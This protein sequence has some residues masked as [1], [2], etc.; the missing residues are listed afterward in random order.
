M[1]IDLGQVSH[2]GIAGACDAKGLLS[3]KCRFHKHRRI[4]G[5]KPAKSNVNHNG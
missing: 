2:I 3:E 4:Y 5:E 1:N